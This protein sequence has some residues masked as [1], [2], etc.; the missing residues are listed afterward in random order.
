M[1]EDAPPGRCCRI[2]S[3]MPLGVSSTSPIFIYVQTGILRLIFTIS[4][5]E[6]VETK[7]KL[8]LFDEFYS[9]GQLYA[10]TN[11]HVLDYAAA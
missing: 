3:Y 10:L 11:S 7:K 2:F 8:S 6:L 9:E 4:V 5:L 1:I